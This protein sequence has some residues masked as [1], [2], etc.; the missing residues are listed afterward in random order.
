VLGPRHE[1]GSDREDQRR[2]RDSRGH[3]EQAAVALAL[4]TH[5]VDQRPLDRGVVGWWLRRFRR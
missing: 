5:D 1:R 4:P 2:D 3:P